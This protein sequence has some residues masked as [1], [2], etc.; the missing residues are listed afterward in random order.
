MGGVEPD[1]LMTYCI[2][3]AFTS[4]RPLHKVD[5]GHRGDQYTWQHS[6][7]VLEYIGDYQ[8][9]PYYTYRH[10]Q[11]NYTIGRANHIANGTTNL[12]HIG[13]GH[14]HAS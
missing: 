12:Y 11:T 10:D 5:L 2:S 14:Y 9:L 4:L 7:D 1:L 3:Q 8:S 13:E 6:K